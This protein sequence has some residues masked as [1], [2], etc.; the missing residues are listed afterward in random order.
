M[1]YLAYSLPLLLPLLSACV[2]YEFVATE[3][4]QELELGDGEYNLRLFPTLPWL[5][6]PAS[7]QESLIPT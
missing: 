1:N 6:P 3:P 5:V 7:G 2:E 4:V